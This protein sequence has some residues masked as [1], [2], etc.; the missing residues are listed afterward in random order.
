MLKQPNTGVSSTSSSCYPVWQQVIALVFR[1]ST[2]LPK[3]KVFQK[4]PG[5]DI[6]TFT[7]SLHFPPRAPDKLLQLSCFSLGVPFWP[8]CSLCSM[9]KSQWDCPT[10]V[11]HTL[12]LIIFR[13]FTFSSCL[14]MHQGDTLLGFGLDHHLKSNC[15]RN[16]Q[17][18]CWEC[19]KLISCVKS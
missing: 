12:P 1:N 18:S 10:H 2:G 14:L 19:T 6:S 15:K 17:W 11:Q 13:L 16:L 4:F 9:F 3:I 5:M 7:Y 8:H